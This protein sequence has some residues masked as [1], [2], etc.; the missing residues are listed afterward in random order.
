MSESKFLF[1]HFGP[2]GNAQVERAWLGA[3]NSHIEFWDYTPPQNANHSFSELVDTYIQ[4]IESSHQPLALVGHSFGANV[5]IAIHQQIPERIISLTLLS[6]LPKAAPAF[7][8]LG[9]RIAV[10]QNPSLQNRVSSFESF[11]KK[12]SPASDVLNEMWSLVFEIAQAPN[13]YSSYWASSSLFEKYA[14][15]CSKCKPL[16]FA[17]WQKTLSDFVINH[18]KDQQIKTQ[19][20]VRI[21]LGD[22][23]PY[24]LWEEKLYWVHM[25]GEKNVT[26]LQNCGHHPHLE[27][28]CLTE[29]LKG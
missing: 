11:L 24:Y 13:F 27:A 23:D 29:L 19:V 7:L 2:G 5:A 20:P 10:L 17:V 4:K 16:D 26:I 3:Q 12:Q 18:E 9:R 15:L 6:P 22:K 8:N 1:I 14:A 25:V 28:N 21:F